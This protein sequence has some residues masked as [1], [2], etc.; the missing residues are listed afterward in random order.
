[1]GLD[2]TT[3]LSFFW[4]LSFKPAFSLSSFTLIKRLFSSSSF[5]AIKSGIICIS[6]IVDISPS[7]LDS[8]LWFIQ[9]GIS[10]DVLCINCF[11]SGSDSKES[12]CNVGDPSSLPGSARPPGE[13]HGNPLQYSCMENPMDRGGWQVTAWRHRVGHN[14][15]DLAHIHA[16]WT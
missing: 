8:S 11:P 14:W 15:S 5:S 10:Q 12:T 13:E 3:F 2:A 4:K 9:P 6:E 16:L 1:M 7:S